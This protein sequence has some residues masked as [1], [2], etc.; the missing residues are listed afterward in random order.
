MKKRKGAAMFP[1]IARLE[2]IPAVIGTRVNQKIASPIPPSEPINETL[3]A[4][5]VGI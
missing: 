2:A 1:S 4:R 5:I 3:T